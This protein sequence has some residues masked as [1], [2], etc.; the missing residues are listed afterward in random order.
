GIPKTWRNMNGYGSHTYMWVNDEGERFWVRFHFLT[1]QGLEHLS[2]EEAERMAGVDAEH[3]RRDLYEAMARGDNPS[4]ELYV[5]IIPYE[6]AKTYRHNIIDLT[7]TIPQ[8]DYPRIKAGTTEP[9][10]NPEKFIAKIQQPASSSA[11]T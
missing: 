9:N 5:Q 1:N 11:N 3:H 6:D 4:W 8:A 7:K 10:R 2:N